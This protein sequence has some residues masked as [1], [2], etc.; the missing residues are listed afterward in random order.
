MIEWVI[1]F[2]EAKRL[3]DR[4]VKE[5]T[6][7]LRNC[8]CSGRKSKVKPSVHVGV[9]CSNGAQLS[10]CF[11][12]KLYE[13]FSYDMEGLE[14]SRDHRDAMRGTWGRCKDFVWQVSCITV[15]SQIRS[16]EV[17]SLTTWLNFDPTANSE[18]ER[19]FRKNPLLS[20]LQFTDMVLD[21]EGGT[22]YSS[23]RQQTYYIRCTHILPSKISCWILTDAGYRT[24]SQSFHAAGIQPYSVHPVTGEAVF[25]LGR[26]TYSTCDW[27]DFGGLKS[28]RYV[29]ATAAI[30]SYHGYPYKGSIHVIY[31]AGCAFVSCMIPT[32]CM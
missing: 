19:Q 17:F 29:Y 31:C 26:I 4:M 11:V 21:F 1:S 32:L 5:I 24:A 6:T 2:P 30:F 7:A 25:L 12:E 20:R 10:P 27:C 18:S 23:Q 14:V 13:H 28:S 9:V 15:H 16:S 3:F 22:A 8:Q